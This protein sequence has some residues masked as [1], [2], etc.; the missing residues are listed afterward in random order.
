MRRTG[1]VLMTFRAELRQRWKAWVGLGLLIGLVGG[2]VSGAVAAGRH[3]DAAYPQF[4]TKT[5]GADVVMGYNDGVGPPLS[6]VRALPQVAT[7]DREAHFLAVGTIDGHALAPFSQTPISPLSSELGQTDNRYTLLSGHAPDPGQADQVMVS[8]PMRQRFGAHAGSVLRMS[9]YSAAEV[10]LVNAGNPIALPP[11]TGPTLDLQVVGVF[12]WVRAFP[13]GASGDD[14]DG[15]FIWLTPAFVRQLGSQAG[16]LTYDVVHLRNGAADVGGVIAA[17]QSFGAY[18]SN[19][20]AQNAVVERSIHLQAIAWWI[21]AGLAALA[22]LAVVGQALARQAIADAASNPLLRSL[23]MAPSE[24]FNL[25]LVRAGITAAV[26]AAGTLL[27]G[28]VLSPLAPIGEARVAE[29]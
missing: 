15:A 4:V 11:P 8:F 23:G 14:A 26:G 28:Y 27:V 1:S 22:G 2:V 29:I 13:T 7:A 16:S 6:S 20:D 9:F 18:F 24:L 12:A 19:Q 17:S 25:G 3:T 21:F 10:P 5:R